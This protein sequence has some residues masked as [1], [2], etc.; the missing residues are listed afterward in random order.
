MKFTTLLYSAALMCVAIAP[1][2][3]RKTDGRGEK[4][5]AA[6]AASLEDSIRAVQQEIDSCKSQIEFLRQDIAG[7]LP[8]FTTVSNPREVGSYMILTQW[9]GRYP[10]TQTGVVAR[11]DNNNRFELIAANAKPF[12]RITVKSPTSAVSS[13]LVPNDQ[14]LNYRTATLTTVMFAGDEADAIGRL[15]AD[16][17]LNPLSVIFE[18]G[19]PVNTWKMPLETSKMIS[20]TYAL[21][22]NTRDMQR[23]ERRVPMLHE[24]INLIRQHKDSKQ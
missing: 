23:L 19:S 2:C 8:N 13:A 16:N 21:Y 15:V 6:Y 9:K 18:Y 14:A 3:G 24:K 4:A 17:A 22:R 20:L 7:L 12:D 10:L 5:K 11:I 1:A